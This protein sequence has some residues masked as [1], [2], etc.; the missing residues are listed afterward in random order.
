MGNVANFCETEQLIEKRSSGVA[1]S[2][3]Q[4]RGSMPMKWT[5]TPDIYYKPKVSTHMKIGDNL[6]VFPQVACAV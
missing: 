3:L 2:Y 6:I 5:Q 1:A 4:T